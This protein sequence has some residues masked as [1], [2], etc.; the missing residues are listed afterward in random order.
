MELQRGTV[1]VYTYSQ[2]LSDSDVFLKTPISKMAQKQK[3][4]E[5]IFGKN[6]LDCSS[7]TK[8]NEQRTSPTA[9]VLHGAEIVGVYFS[10][11]N[12]QS[13]DFIKKLKDL[14][15]RI[16]CSANSDSSA[17]KLEV[18]QVVL[19]AHN[20]VYSDFETSHRDNLLNLP[21]FAVP[22]NEIELKT[23]LSRRY[24]IKSGVPTLVLLDKDGG[25]ISAAAQERLLED[26]TGASFPW[27]PRPVEQVLKDIVLQ[28]GGLY[29][30]EHQKSCNDV[31]YS[32]IPAGVKGF[33]FSAHWCPPC[34]A[35]TPQL[36][37]VYRLVRKREPTFEIIFVSSDR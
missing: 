37:E 11:A 13:D 3:W 20:D 6:L 8:T 23:R 5:K 4:Q 25:T 31:T 1:E 35:F 22:Y 17:R 18:V 24:R 21:W 34:K 28:P 36:A 26:P 9:D 12:M 15:E 10:F 32:D 7:L 29:I 33:Y 19:W 30:K 27:R 2:N 14:Y 16:N